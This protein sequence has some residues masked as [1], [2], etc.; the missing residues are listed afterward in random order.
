MSKPDSLMAI[1]YR[2]KNNVIRIDRDRAFGHHVTSRTSGAIARAE[3][4][5]RRWAERAVRHA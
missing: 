5:I 2:L 3:E 4:E 1:L